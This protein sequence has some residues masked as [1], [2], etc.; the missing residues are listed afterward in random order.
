MSIYDRWVFPP[1]LDLVMRQRQIEKYRRELIPAARGRVLEVGVGSGLNLRLYAAGVNMVV[2]L[3]PSER[4]LSMARRR[5]AKAEVSVDLVHGS[6]TAIPL[7]NDSVDMVV[8]TWTLCSL[9]SMA[10]LRNPASRD[11]SI[12]SRRY[13]AISPADV[14][15]TGKSTISFA[16]PASTFPS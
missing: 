11:G 2:G 3:D 14:T 10:C 8:M 16:R 12:G 1:L 6:A 13:G 9:W 4:L 7:D 15:S 5:A